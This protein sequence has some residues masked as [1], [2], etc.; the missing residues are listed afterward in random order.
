MTKSQI[1]RK[2][3]KKKGIPIIELKMSQ[4]LSIEEARDLM[5]DGLPKEKRS[6]EER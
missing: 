3:A 4:G 1:I 5:G 2:M 6:S